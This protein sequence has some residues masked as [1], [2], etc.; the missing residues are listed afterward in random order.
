MCLSDL[1]PKV[2]GLD[3][4]M[5]VFPHVAERI[6][7]GWATMLNL[8][9]GTRI[10]RY[11]C[12]RGGRVWRHRPRA[13]SW[14]H[15]ALQLDYRLEGRHLWSIPWFV[16]C[17]SWWECSS[18]WS[19]ILMFSEDCEFCLKLGKWPQLSKVW[20]PSPRRGWSE[21]WQLLDMSQW[22]E[23]CLEYK[24]REEEEL[25]PEVPRKRPWAERMRKTDWFIRKHTSA[26][27]LRGAACIVEHTEFHALTL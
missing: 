22:L 15:G 8:G 27:A 6:A 18:F 4:T 21:R 11:I 16:Q 14:A 9:Y 24:Q 17:Y 2:G 10:P 23:L 5:V 7:D 19:N 13:K 26:S 20:N 12:G 1:G 25:S 3:L